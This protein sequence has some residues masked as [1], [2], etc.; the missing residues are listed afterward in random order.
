MIGTTAADKHTSSF[1]VRRKRVRKV[2]AAGD[3]NV[4]SPVV[5][6]STPLVPR[7]GGAT[8]SRTVLGLRGGG[9]F[10]QTVGRPR[11]V[12]KCRQLG[13]STT[14]QDLANNTGLAG[15]SARRTKPPAH[16][17][18][19]AVRPDGAWRALTPLR[20]P[21]GA[22]AHAHVRVRRTAHSN[23]FNSRMHACACGPATAQPGNSQHVARPAWRGARRC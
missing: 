12:A 18:F 6:I 4:G 3:T 9:S 19:P 15:S 22:R 20:G 14:T 21:G 2:F 13:T 10:V 7:L 17:C 16:L 8:S 11:N 23:S 5:T 1:L